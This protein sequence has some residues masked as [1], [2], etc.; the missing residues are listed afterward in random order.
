[1]RCILLVLDGLGDKGHACLGGKTPLQAAYTPNLDRLASMGVNGLYHTCLQGMAMPSEIAHFLMFGY[2]LDEFPGRG[3]L[4]AMGEGITVR[5]DEVYVLARLCSVKRNKNT[6][7]LH[8]ESPDVDGPACRAL[9]KAI[10]HYQEGPVAIEFVPTR[11]ILGLLR[12]SGA[13]SA[14][15]TD[16]NPMAEG[17]PLMEILPFAGCED[18]TQAQATA[19]AM[20][21]YLKWCYRTLSRHPR[22]VERSRRGLL[23]A[24]AVGTQRPGMKKPLR[25]FREKWGLRSL[26]IS[27]GPV[28]H[29]LCSLLSIKNQP[30]AE[31]ADPEE[32]LRRRLRL[33]KKASGYDF[34]HVHTKAPD[35]A[36]H[37]KN[38]EHK[39]AVIESLDRA[40]EY[41]LDELAAD[42]EVLLAVTADHSTASI[43]AMIHSGETVPLTFVGKYARRDAV[44]SF[45]E[46]SCAGG[47]LGQVRGKE[48]MY[49]IL[50]MLDRGKLW[51]TMDSPV[52]QPFVPGK[53]KALRIR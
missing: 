46:V 15:I 13:V 3:L 24:N 49:L 41:A 18:R 21:G 7:V 14:Q 38:P 17:R 25:P 5:D 9:Q 16:S 42:D 52:N 45:D 23:P 31:M 10:R 32:D 19:G 26:S 47:G 48:L 28:Y 4:E 51:G 29:G 12:L 27:S 36:S 2:E 11:G 53:Y 44:S 43:G 50:N 34:I 37:T 8:H 35:E 22:N 40:L 6:L 20:N 30:V 39:K 33:A 1:M